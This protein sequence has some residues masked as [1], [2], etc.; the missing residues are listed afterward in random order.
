MKTAWIKCPR[1]DVLRREETDI[2]RAVVLVAFALMFLTGLLI[3]SSSPAAAD[4]TAVLEGGEGQLQ[5]FVRVGS[6]FDL[7]ES[8]RPI[9]LEV[10]V[11]DIHGLP[12]AGVPVLLTAPTGT[13]SPD[14]VVTDET[15]RASFTFLA[16]VG[17][18]TTVRIL[19]KTNLDGAA[20]GVDAFFVRVVHLPPPPIYAR[21]EVLSIGVLSGLLVFASWTE[22]GR[23][24]FFGLFFP[25]Y[26]RI[27]REEVLDHFLRGQVYGV[28][29]TQP[30]SNFTAIR[31][32]LS[33]SNGTLSYHLRTLESSGFVVS[34]RDGLY[35]RFFAAD[36]GA[37]AAQDGVRLSELQRRLL[38]RLRHSPEVGQRDLAKDAGVTQQCISYNLR[39][40]GQQGLVVKVRSGRGHRY[41]V[42]DG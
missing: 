18:S 42:V 25:L 24:A 8:G 4:G 20:Q 36:L 38:E 31:T 7:A 16:D 41:I 27:K 14:V 39:I 5:I 33:L 12:R 17:E 23:H 11:T 26:T 34:E 29:K 22:P 30:G 10:A 35:K 1:V 9:P 15:G 28:I 32:L 40:M 37:A 21:A 13:V 3:L 2:G 19:A 6:S